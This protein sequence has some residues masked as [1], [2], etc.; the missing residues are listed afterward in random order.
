M[1]VGVPFQASRSKNIA[2][3]I[4]AFFV[5]GKELMRDANLSNPKDEIFIL[6]VAS[7]SVGSVLGI[8]SYSYIYT[9][10][11]LRLRNIQ[12]ICTFLKG[13]EKKNQKVKLVT[14]RDAWEYM[15]SS[16]YNLYNLKVKDVK[17]VG[18]HVAEGAACNK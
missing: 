11:G 1:L 4:A 12:K 8:S 10:D 16:K 2:A 5:V 3:F 14:R 6:D 7:A 17:L 9:V 15:S 18:P 13:A